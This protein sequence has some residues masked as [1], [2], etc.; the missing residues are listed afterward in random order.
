MRKQKSLLATLL[1][2]VYKFVRSVAF[3]K[4]KIFLEVPAEA[5]PGILSWNMGPLEEGKWK[6]I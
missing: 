4:M 2:T 3:C 6:T 5:S 1:T